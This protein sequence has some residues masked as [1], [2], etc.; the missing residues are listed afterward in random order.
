MAR[1]AFQLTAEI[2]DQA[3][4][5]YLNRFDSTVSNLRRVLVRQ[6]GNQIARE[7]E[8]VAQGPAEQQARLL[9]EA[10]LERYQRSGVLD[11][12]RYATH[13][14]DAL[15]R[16]GTSTRAIR[17]K[18]AHKGVPEATVVQAFENEELRGD[19]D[20]TETRDP[21]LVAAKNYA[22]RRRLG[23]Y[24]SAQ[25]TENASERKQKDLATLARAG[26][27]YAVASAALRLDDPSD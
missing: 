22:K 2:V 24:R 12:L 9:I 8:P 13:R 25:K 6:L 18:L 19:D 5:K 20:D 26:F 10:L 21:D 11:D 17:Q 3:A 1:A 16:R 15:R 27:S 23:P 4:L 7:L 14:V